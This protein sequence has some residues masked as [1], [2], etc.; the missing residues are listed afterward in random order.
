MDNSVLCKLS[1][2]FFC[3]LISPL[4]FISV[5]ISICQQGVLLNTCSVISAIKEMKIH[6]I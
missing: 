6:G 1:C 5:A 3:A 2:G 4:T